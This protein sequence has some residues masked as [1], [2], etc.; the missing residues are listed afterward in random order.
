MWQL[1]A[2]RLAPFWGVGL[3]AA[4]FCGRAAVF[5]AAAA[6]LIIGVVL[7]VRRDKHTL[8]AAGFLAGLIVMSLCRALYCAPLSEYCSQTVTAEL[9]ITDIP[10]RYTEYTI[11]TA[12]TNLG[13][14]SALVRL[15]GDDSADIGDTITAEVTFRSTDE[16][17]YRLTN[18]SK[19]ILL[20]ASANSIS[21]TER[22]HTGIRR[23][24]YRLRKLFIGY[25]ERFVGGEE[26]ALAAAMFFGESGKL[27]ASL[28][29][30]ICVSG[31]SHFTAVSGTH[32]AVISMMLIELFAD[33]NRF[34]R[35][36]ASL[37]VVP[38][39]VMFF[40]TGSSVIRSALMVLIC[41]CA[42]L[43]L[44]KSET[45][46]SLC[47]A[48][49]IITA[50]QPLAALDVGLWMSVLGVFGVVAGSRVG[51]SAVRRLP[52][53]IRFLSGWVNLFFVSLGA[54]VCT[55]PISIACFGG[56]SLIGPFVSALLMPLFSA[57]MVLVFIMGVTSSP[58]TALPSAIILRLMLWII[59]AAG[60]LR[61]LWI[62]MD[63][64]GAVLLAA[65]GGGL[66]VWGAFVLRRRKTAHP[67]AAAVLAVMLSISTI[68]SAGRCRIDFVSDG[69]SGAAVVCVGNSA[70]VLI[71]GTGE[72]LAP[73]LA[74]CLR[75]NGISRISFV[76]AG[77]LNFCGALALGELTE[78]V[79]S[80]KIYAPLWLH[81]VLSQT[82]TA[83]IA[84][85]NASSILVDDMEIIS[86]K[87]GSDVE[88]D[89]VLY[90]GYTRLPPETSVQTAVYCS[91][92]QNLL[93]E[94]GVN[95]YDE[96]FTLPLG[97]AD[98]ITIIGKAE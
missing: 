97:K 90:Y 20:S 40:G 7:V 10:R 43:F 74:E 78:I 54:T 60:K 31:I 93:P 75:R 24:M 23:M 88:G 1:P 41:N 53:R 63:Y 68:T 98:T 13:G 32:F 82:C 15:Y 33:K 96:S 36:L 62:P 67:L 39:A 65:L 61:F 4:Y 52:R 14:R 6:A 18:L 77:E 42:P 79:P 16:G 17:E 22:S 81:E 3:V 2:V 45:I 26:S 64:L 35:A 48:F 91:S 56:I 30:A 55:A 38:F 72:R 44:R 95:V 46:N 66:F 87:A 12:R 27:S 85:Y 47:A 37:V 50:V 5:A 86:A 59:K 76:A 89:V 29:E 84:P 25:T 94:N 28:S 21:V 19:G 34:R 92:K 83:Q 70:S 8:C 71:S 80:G 11:Y 69:T 57:G 9:T 49:L 51:A 73:K 58:V